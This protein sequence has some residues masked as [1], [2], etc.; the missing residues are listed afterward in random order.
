[1]AHILVIDDDPSVCDVVE[2]LLDSMGFSVTSATSGRAA[3]DA[4][5]TQP[6]AAAIVDLC[7]P[8]MPGLEIIRKLRALAPDT[9]L[10]VMSGLMSDCGSAPAPDFLGM[11]ADL[12]GV[13]RLPKPFGREE[14]FNLL[15]DC[16]GAP[17][18][19]TALVG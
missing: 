2:K 11:A 7:M 15:G 5:T 1:V 8:V 13:G 10:I 4:A 12:R 19:R 18:G 17:Q 16:L 3:L 9:R 6:F 14:L